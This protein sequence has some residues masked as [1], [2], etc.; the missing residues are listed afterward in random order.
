MIINFE[1]CVRRSESK[2]SELASVPRSLHSALLRRSRLPFLKASR[3]VTQGE[4][5]AVDYLSRV[6]SRLSSSPS[7]SRTPTPTPPP[8]LSFFTVH[9][10]R[11]PGNFVSLT[12]CSSAR[13]IHSPF[14]PSPHYCLYPLWPSVRVW[15][16]CRGCCARVCVCHN[17]PRSPLPSPAHSK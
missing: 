1:V 12:R 14:A 10:S 6:S 9:C 16:A 2:R 8:P 11:K 5:Q 3:N 15:C 7:S 17:L 13:V 4:L